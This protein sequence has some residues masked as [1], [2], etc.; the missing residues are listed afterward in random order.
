MRSSFVMKEQ[1]K[2]KENGQCHNDPSTPPSAGPVSKLPQTDRQKVGINS[3]QSISRQSTN[4]TPTTIDAPIRRP[5]Q[6]TPDY[7]PHPNYKVK[8]F[9]DT[10][11]MTTHLDPQDRKRSSSTTYSNLLIMPAQQPQVPLCRRRRKKEAGYRPHQKVFVG[12]RLW[13]RISST[14]ERRS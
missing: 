13:L 4:S 5:G 14:W 2:F 9:I 10:D 11:P 1:K 6:S 12:D 8:G 3:P 7:S